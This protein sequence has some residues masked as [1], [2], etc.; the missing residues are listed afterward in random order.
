MKDWI[1]DHYEEEELCTNDAIRTA[2]WEA[3]DAVPE[4]I[5]E[6]L[7]AE[8]PARC[9]AVIDANGMHTRY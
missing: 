3:W 2:V 9:Q 5:L 4:Q 6:D 7:I 8:M 1:Q